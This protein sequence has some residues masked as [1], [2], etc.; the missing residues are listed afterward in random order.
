MLA[1]ETTRMIKRPLLA[2]A[3]HALERDP[4]RARHGAAFAHQAADASFGRRS[5]RLVFVLT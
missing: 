2:A 1:R 3:L 5:T 4:F